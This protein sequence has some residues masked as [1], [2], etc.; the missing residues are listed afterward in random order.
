[1]HTAQWPCF[2]LVARGANSLALGH[3]VYDYGVGDYLV[4]A[5]DVPVTSRTTVASQKAPL[6]GLGM[7]IR[8]ERL[9]E[10]FQRLPPVPMAS[11][12]RARGVGVNQADG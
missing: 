8:P 9:Q 4:V 1:M 7:A 2:A 6:L 3:E 11:G 5:L 10:L 12:D